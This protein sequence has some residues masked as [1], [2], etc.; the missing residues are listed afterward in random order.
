MVDAPRDVDYFVSKKALKTTET[1]EN[2][3]KEKKSKPHTSHV[4][5]IYLHEWLF[6]MVNVG[7]LTIH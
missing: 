7:K 4:R 5:S 6:F 2:G 3:G 1:A